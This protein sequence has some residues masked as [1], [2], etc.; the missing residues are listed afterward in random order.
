MIAAHLGSKLLPGSLST[1]RL[2]S[3]LLGTRHLH[4]MLI[5]SQGKSHAHDLLSDQSGRGRESTLIKPSNIGSFCV[6]HRMKGTGNNLKSVLWW[7]WHCISK[8]NI[9]LFFVCNSDET[10]KL[11]ASDAKIKK[12]YKKIRKNHTESLL[13]PIIS[14][15][16]QKRQNYQTNKSKAQEP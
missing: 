16:H 15:A 11:N 13:Q 14:F 10:R 1:S 8:R 6:F 5:I 3:S 9:E 7:R 2:T 4:G 12:K